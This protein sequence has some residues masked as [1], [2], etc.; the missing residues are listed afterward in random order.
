MISANTPTRRLIWAMVIVAGLWSLG[1][2]L[3]GV[4]V[5]IEAIKS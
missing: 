2:L 3:P 4:A 5:L 1:Q